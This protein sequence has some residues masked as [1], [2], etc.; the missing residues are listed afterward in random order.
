M[1]SLLYTGCES[2]SL[3]LVAS[4]V[5]FDDSQNV[6]KFMKNTI[7]STMGTIFAQNLQRGE[8]SFLTVPNIDI[9]LYRPD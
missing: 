5:S 1:S 9:M 2:L 6:E 4:L 7:S 3:N 8:T